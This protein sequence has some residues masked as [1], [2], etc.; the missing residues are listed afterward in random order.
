MQFIGNEIGD[1]FLAAYLELYNN[2]HR[3]ATMLY[4]K[5]G[6]SGSSLL[7]VDDSGYTKMP[8]PAAVA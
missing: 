4:R 6:V 3:T 7:P 1:G 2:S 8:D 5:A